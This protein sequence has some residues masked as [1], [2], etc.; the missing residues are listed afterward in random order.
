MQQAS[1]AVLARTPRNWLY[2][3]PLGKWAIEEI[4][5]SG[6]MEHLHEGDAIGLEDHIESLY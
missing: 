6:A 3:R 4:F 2:Y 5:N 1:D